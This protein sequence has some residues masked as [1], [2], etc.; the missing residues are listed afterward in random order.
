MKIIDSMFQTNKLWWE[1]IPEI[2][3]LKRTEFKVK[4]VLTANNWPT[5]FDHYTAFLRYGN[6]VCLKILPYHEI[7]VFTNFGKIYVAKLHFT[8]ILSVTSHFCNAGMPVIT[9]YFTWIGS[10][11][12]DFKAMSH[13]LNCIHNIYNWYLMSIITLKHMC[14]RST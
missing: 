11:N 10:A 14:V 2:F 9:P 1:I 5:A 3:R 6:A 4:Y 13:T 8:V 7:F 12:N